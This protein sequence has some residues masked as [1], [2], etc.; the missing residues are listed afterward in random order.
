MSAPRLYP[1]TWKAACVC[2]TVAAAGSRHANIAATHTPP[3]GCSLCIGD[4]HTCQGPGRQLA[5]CHS[6][7]VVVE[8]PRLLAAVRWRR[9][10]HIQVHQPALA[11][12]NQTHCSRLRLL[13]YIV[14]RLARELNEGTFT[15]LQAERDRLREQLA[16]VPGM[17]R[18]LVSLNGMLGAGGGDGGGSDS[19]EEGM[20]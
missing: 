7:T 8:V 20:L 19:D 6:Q 3:R 11:P 1:L 12:L 18:R 16:D 14:C 13:F 4:R 5:H 10:L 9:R 17:Q 2:V 15:S